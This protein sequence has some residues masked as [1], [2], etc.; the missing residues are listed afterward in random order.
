MA[1][2]SVNSIFDVVMMNLLVLKDKPS[3]ESSKSRLTKKNLFGANNHNDLNC[4]MI[5]NLLMLTTNT[6]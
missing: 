2:V 1:L 5:G 4:T 3:F 6:V